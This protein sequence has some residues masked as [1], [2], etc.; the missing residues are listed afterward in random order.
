MNIRLISLFFAVFISATAVAELAPEK[1]PNVVTLPTSYPDTWIFAHDTNFDA[2]IAGRVVILDVAADAREYKGALDAAQFA[3]FVESPARSEMYV[4]ETFYSRGTRGE[5]T[6]VVSIYD[7]ASLKQV[8]EIVLPGGKRAMTVTNKF[9]MRLIDDDRYLLIFNFTPASSVVVIDTTSRKILN[10]VPIPGCS[11][12]YPSG[13][14]GFSSLCGDGGLLSVNLNENGEVESQ[15]RLNAMFDVD[16]DPLFDK[17]V[18]IGDV[19]YFPSFLGEV[20]T[21]KMGAE[22]KPIKRWSLLNDKDK[23]DNWRPSG[24]QIASADQHHLYVLMQKNGTLG[25]HKNG[26]EEVWVFDPVSHKRV[27]RIVLENSGFSIQAVPGG[28]GYLVVTEPA[29][30]IAVYSLDG[31]LLRTIGGAAAM[32]LVLH[33]QQ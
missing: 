27:R 30:D 13:T 21:V 24:W 22:P 29:M 8:G 10:E 14:R 6:D 4:A 12:I 11:M 5:R 7:K 18:Y 25:S 28:D 1:I 20:Q 33:A 16:V 19:A 17:P 32:P 15:H 2:L 31:K 26:G 23:A 3:T 9:S